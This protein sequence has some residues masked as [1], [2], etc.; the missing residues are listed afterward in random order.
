MRTAQQS[1]LS[2]PLKML[3][4]GLSEFL[5]GENENITEEMKIYIDEVIGVINSD[6]LE[7]ETLVLCLVYKLAKE[8]KYSSFDELKKDLFA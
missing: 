4:D 5:K 1:K 3:K 8:N 7:Y 6:A 2:T